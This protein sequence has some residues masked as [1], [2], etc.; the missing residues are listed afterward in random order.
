MNSG[1]MLGTFPTK[2]VVRNSALVMNELKDNMSLL[3]NSLVAVGAF[4]EKSTSHDTRS[5]QQFDFILQSIQEM[6][7][8]LSRLADQ[9]N[10]ADTVDPEVVISPVKL[11]K[12]RAIMGRSRHS[13][14]SDLDQTPNEPIQLF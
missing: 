12:L 7:F 10:D 9:M 3:E 2:L 1:S 11:A 8:L 14:L 4:H 5:I 13:C 6:S